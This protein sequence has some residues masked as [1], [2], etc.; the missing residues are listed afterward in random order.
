MTAKPTTAKMI[1]TTPQAARL[2]EVELHRI[3]ASPFNPRT[4]F[5]EEALAELAA[6]IGEQGVL[7]PIIVR[8][9]SLK[10]EVLEIVAGERRFRAAKLAKLETIPCL[11]RDLDDTQARIIA[12]TENKQ[13]SDLD[14][15]DEARGYQ[16]LKEGGMAQSEISERLGVSAG[17]VSKSLALLQL[18][19]GVQEQLRTGVLSV[20][21]AK[22]ILSKY[23]RFKEVLPV[24]AGYAITNA[25]TVRQLENPVSAENHN[26]QL[27]ARLIE[28]G[29]ARDTQRATFDSE[30]CGACP[31]KAQMRIGSRLVC[32]LPEEFDR[33]ETEATEKATAEALLIAQRLREANQKTQQRASEPEDAK[34]TKTPTLIN[35]KTLPYNTYERLGTVRPT[36]CS[37]ECPCIGVALDHYKN[38]A[39]CKICT[40]PKRYQGLQAADTRKANKERRKIGDA[41]IAEIVAWNVAPTPTEPGMFGEEGWWAVNTRRSALATVLVAHRMLYSV[42]VKQRRAVC[43]TLLK[44]ERREDILPMLDFLNAEGNKAD[45]LLGALLTWCEASAMN[46]EQLIGACAQIVALAEVERVIG[47][48]G[49]YITPEIAHQ[50]LERKPLPGYKEEAKS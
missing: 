48:G 38:N 5:D 43:N 36:G 11:I 2:E 8:S 32:F 47:W 34:T 24:V 15:L 26:W 21:Q 30:Q 14:P 3:V 49:G 35:L 7:E 1:A 16:I 28:S 31:H 50:L 39:P 40:D 37:D 22:V 9:I 13:R 20:G 33:K 44:S 42:G 18:P 19:E 23:G 46:R 17:E 45:K 25:S 12:V 4:R 41:D 27:S 29:V 6:S 10:G